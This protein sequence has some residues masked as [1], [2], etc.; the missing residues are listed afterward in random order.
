VA[1][2]LLFLQVEAQQL[3]VPNAFGSM[4][5]EAGAVG[6]NAATSHDNTR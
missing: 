1:P 5:Q 6:L 3:V 4:L 2:A